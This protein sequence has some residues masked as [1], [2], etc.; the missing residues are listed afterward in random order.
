MTSRTATNLTRRT[1]FGA[2]GVAGLVPTACGG[3]GGGG[4][5][6]AAD[7]Y[8]TILANKVVTLSEDTFQET[9]GSAH[10]V[11]PQSFTIWMD[12]DSN[13]THIAECF[14]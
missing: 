12:Q 1:F 4:G 2:A 13:K 3:N 8:V 5:T 14:E 9:V 7:P 10:V 6:E 11:A